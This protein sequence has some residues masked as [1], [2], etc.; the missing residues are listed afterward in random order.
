M[1]FGFTWSISSD[2]L[3]LSN[4]KDALIQNMK[5]L[6]TDVHISHALKGFV[7]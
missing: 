6:Q 3:I 4:I 5:L 1:L 2:R 7:Q